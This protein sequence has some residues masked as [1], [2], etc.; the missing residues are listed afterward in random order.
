VDHLERYI[1]GKKRLSARKLKK[2]I[3]NAQ[4]T[5]EEIAVSARKRAMDYDYVLRQQRNLMYETRDSLLDDGGELEPDRVLELARNNIK[6]FMKAHKKLDQQVLSRYL[7]ENISYGLDQTL[8]TLKYRRRKDRKQVEQYLIGRVEEGLRHQELMLKTQKSMND[9]MR[10]AAL[11]AIDD[12]WVEQVD[13]LQQLQ[14]AVSG[15][16]LAQRNLIYEYQ[17]DAL[18]SFKEMEETILQNIMRNIL[19]SNVYLDEQKKLHILLP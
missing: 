6:K 9:F 19:L 2:M 1:E 4:K 15:R 17:K 14:S 3:N 12:A 5:G 16:A 13:Y 18:E 8:P 11:N 7:L 10:V